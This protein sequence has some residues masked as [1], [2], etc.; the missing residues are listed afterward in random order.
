VNVNNSTEVGPLVFLVINV[1]NHREYYETL[2][3]L[4]HI[5]SYGRQDMEGPNR[6]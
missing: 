5:I 2:C 6:L 4:H 3:I 1:C